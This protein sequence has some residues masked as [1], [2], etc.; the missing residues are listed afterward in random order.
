MRIYVL[1]TQCIHAENWTDFG[2]IEIELMCRIEQIKSALVKIVHDYK[3]RAV[4][5]KKVNLHGKQN[6]KK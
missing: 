3:T 5:N 6:K 1:D 4:N 2:E